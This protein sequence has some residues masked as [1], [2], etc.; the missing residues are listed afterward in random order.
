MVRPSRASALARALLLGALRDY[1][2]EGRFPKNPGFPWQIPVFVDHEGT[3]CAIAHL[4]ELGGAGTLV[5]E[6]SAQ[7]NFAFVRE[8][9]DDPRVAAWL[10]AAGLTVDEAAD[11]QPSYCQTAWSECICGDPWNAPG[12]SAPADAVVEGVVQIMASGNVL[13]V[14]ATYGDAGNVAVG[15]L[16]VI[17]NATSVAGTRVLFPLKRQSMPTFYEPVTPSRVDQNLLLPIDAS[18]RPLRCDRGD[19]RSIPVTKAQVIGAIRSNDCRGEM[20]KVDSDWSDAPSCGE[21]CAC[22]TT[23]SNEADVA[24]LLAVVAAVMARRVG[25]ALR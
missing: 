3:R 19:E 11:I 25:R 8:L 4:M 18:G 22:S 7:R 21:G 9:V 10:S 1:W 2:R 24:V 17:D 16:Y 15:N 5:A 20:N 23:V 12:P 6:I 13:R 14:E